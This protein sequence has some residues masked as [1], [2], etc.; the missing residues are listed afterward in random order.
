[1]DLK[2]VKG[3]LFFVMKKETLDLHLGLKKSTESIQQL[4][5]NVC[6]TYM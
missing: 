2:H 3:P 6:L 5:I 1:M 4:L